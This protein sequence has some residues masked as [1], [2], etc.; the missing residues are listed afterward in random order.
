MLIKAYGSS[1]HGIEAT[2]ITVEVNISPGARFFIVGLA[3]NAIKESQ[4]R[5]ESALKNNGFHWPGT[6]VIVNLAPA[7]IRKEG[8]AFDLPLAVGLLAA[9][10]QVLT[11]KFS[12][13]VM[14][15]ELSLDGGLQRIRGV[16]PMALK[17]RKDK[18]KGL[19]LPMENAREAAVVENLEIIGVESLVEAVGFLNGTLDIKPVKIDT[20]KEFFERVNIFDNDFSE[21]KGQENVKRALEIAVAGG[22]NII[23]I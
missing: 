10:G 3:D 18:F 20:R 2:T 23:M 17:A 6:K 4:Q 21:V 8:T 5:I 12:D 16:L 15:G 22:H 14:T 13:Y 11:D 7:D 9:S 1:V 19:I